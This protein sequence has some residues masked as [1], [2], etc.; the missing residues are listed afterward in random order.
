M[1]PHVSSDSKTQPPSDL[2]HTSSG[3]EAKTKKAFWGIAPE[4]LFLY[5]CRPFRALCPPCRYQA[6]RDGD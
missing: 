1:S 6:R 2:A 5:E 4:G 3:L